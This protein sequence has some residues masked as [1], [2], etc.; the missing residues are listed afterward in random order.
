MACAI[1]PKPRSV[2]TTTERAP[3]FADADER[4]DARKNAEVKASPPVP[5][6]VRS[7]GEV[8]RALGRAR[9]G[10][11]ERAS[12]L[13]RS[14]RSWFDFGSRSFVAE[15]PVATMWIVELDHAGPE[16]GLAKSFFGEQQHNVN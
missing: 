13:R 15:P 1:I 11:W 7:C 4:W 2:T 3:S 6:H 12:L 16:V 5:M 10:R 8:G 14:R 9:T